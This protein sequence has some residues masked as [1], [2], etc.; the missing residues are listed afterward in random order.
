MDVTAKQPDGLI[1]RAARF[2]PDHEIYIRSGGQMRFLRITTGFQMKLAAVAVALFAVW[3]ISSIFMVGLQI[4]TAQDREALAAQQTAV[5]RSVGRIAD[6][7]SDVNGLAARLEKRQA[8]L[9]QMM[10]RY[11]GEVAPAPEMQAKAEFPALPEA[12]PLARVEARQRAFAER[13]TLAAG[14]RAREAEKAIRSYGINPAALMG[15]VGGPY[16]PIKSARPQDSGL[17]RLAVSLRKLDTMER[18]LLAI[19]NTAPATPIVLSSGFGVRSDPF[20][21]G[22][23]LHA[24]LDITGDRG[25]PIYAAA[26]GR[27]VTVGQQ[28][29]YG[30]LVV[31]DHGH[32]ITTRYGHL[33]GFDVRPGQ[34]VTRGQRIA[35]MGS[36]GR[37]TGDHL[38]FEVRMG[39]RAINPRPFLE[40]K[41]DVLK[42]Q[43]DIQRRFGGQ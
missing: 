41:A 2:F 42:V 1:A 20:T 39:E 8:Q 27:V 6:W 36:T 12:A 3:L 34:T 4:K 16:I 38:H 5:E 33:S 14:L 29:G 23:A 28:G 32:G 15:G 18:A 31:I 37:S 7:R 22:A 25:Q 19:P 21:G 30:N 11:F 10:V 40:G 26:A 9:D 17:Q 43:T 35:R 13:L 24:G